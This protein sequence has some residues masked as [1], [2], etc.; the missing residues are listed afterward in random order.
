[1]K[2]PLCFNYLIKKGE[3]LDKN[4]NVYKIFYCSV[5]KLNF[6]EKL[7]DIYNKLDLDK[8][9]IDKNYFYPY[10]VFCNDDGFIN[11]YGKVIEVFLCENNKDTILGNY[12][13]YNI[14]ICCLFDEQLLVNFYCKYKDLKKTL[15]KNE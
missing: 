9:N 11:K 5:C 6:K 4:R 15:L 3:F 13:N 7:L 2:C 12:D 8:F 10:Y 1:M 14:G